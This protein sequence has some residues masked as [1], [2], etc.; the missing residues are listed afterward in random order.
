MQKTSN[1]E[2]II[3]LF[4]KQK[5]IAPHYKSKNLNNLSFLLIRIEFRNV[6]NCFKILPS[7]YNFR[8][9]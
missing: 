4:E 2:K 7:L 6:L 3:K 9:K 1:E 8:R 5:K